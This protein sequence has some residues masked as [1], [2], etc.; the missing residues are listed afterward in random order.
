MPL[1]DDDAL[2]LDSHPFRDAHLLLTVL[3]HGHG[4]VRGVLRG[5]RG[6]RTPQA[7][8]TQVLSLVRVNAF[9]APHAEL[10]SFR[11]VGLL[12]SSYPLA[13]S[14]EHATAAAVVAE[15]LATFCPPAEPAER[16]FRLGAAVL[17]GLLASADPQVAVAYAQHW[18]LALGGVLPPL[19]RC[20]VC[21][22]ALSGEVRL[23]ADDGQA[24]CARCAPA[25]ADR[26]GPDSLEQLAAIRS[27]P[28]REVTAPVPAPLA[29]WLDRLA[30][31]EAERPL[32]ALE[33]FRRY[34][35]G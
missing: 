18:S 7:A 33:F 2:V 22:S 16:F 35:R 31:R 21:S 1:L 17:D 28:I 30:A 10:A 15:L 26:L 3:T 34:G 19:D 20:S 25:A 24:V 6:G 5:A 27:R 9:S 13:A 4:V 29:R 12:R 23:R 11:Q 32:R 14:V 8:A